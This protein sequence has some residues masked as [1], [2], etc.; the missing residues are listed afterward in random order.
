MGRGRVPVH[1]AF[2][3]PPQPASRRLGP[4]L[5]RTTGVLTPCAP[6]AG[7]PVTAQGR[8]QHDRPPPERL[9]RRP[10][11]RTVT[12]HALT[13]APAT[14]LAGTDDTASRHRAVGSEPPPRD[15]R[16]RLI[17]P[18]KRGRVRAGEG[19]VGHVEAPD[20]RRQNPHPRE[21][22]TPAPGTTRRPRP[23]PQT[24]RTRKPTREHANRTPPADPAPTCRPGRDSGSPRR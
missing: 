11:D 10:P 13:A 7:A 5:G 21:T 14:P 16:T 17:K 18:T 6:A 12:R 24:R 3:R 15:L 2:Q 8:L 20:G 4:R 9:V 23:H 19:D 1:D 22:P